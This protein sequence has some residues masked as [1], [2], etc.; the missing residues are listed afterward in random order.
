MVMVNIYDMKEQEKVKL[1]F[2]EQPFVG[3]CSICGLPLLADGACRRYHKLKGVK[4]NKE[5]HG[6]SKSPNRWN[7]A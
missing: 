3:W 5:L 7:N 6:K 2:G 4:R 1:I